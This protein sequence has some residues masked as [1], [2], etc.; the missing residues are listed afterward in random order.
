MYADD[1]PVQL[2]TSWLPLD[3]AKGTAIEQVDTGRGGTYSRLA[4]LGH[5]ITQFA[6]AISVSLPA[7]HEADFLRLG[8]GQLIYNIRRTAADQDGRVVEVTDTTMSVTR[9]GLVYRWPAES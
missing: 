1:I 8:P 9:F 3:I 2:A 7:D 6:E 5:T 4:E